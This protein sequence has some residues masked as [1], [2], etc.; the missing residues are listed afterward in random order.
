MDGYAIHLSALDQMIRAV[1]A[2]A[3]VMALTVIS[4][5]MGR[6]GLWLA[7]P[8]AV[9]LV[10]ATPYVISNANIAL[11]VG[12]AF[13]SAPELVLTVVPTAAFAAILVYSIVLAMAGCSG[14]VSAEAPKG[15]H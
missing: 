3:P 14:L 2:A 7:A 13:T 9:F 5:R 1:V 15:T 4:W 11:K 6:R 10:V 8:W 12:R